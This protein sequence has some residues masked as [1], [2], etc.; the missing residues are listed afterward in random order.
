MNAKGSTRSRRQFVDQFRQQLLGG[1]GL[2]LPAP[3]R[4]ASGLSTL[5]AR[6]ASG[7]AE[8]ASVRGASS[9]WRC[10]SGDGPSAI[11]QESRRNGALALG[12]SL[13]LSPGSRTGLVRDSPALTPGHRA[14]AMPTCAIG[15]YC[16]PLEGDG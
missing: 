15:R 5:C 6:V 16:G 14:S 2:A 1:H 9:S 13:G 4:A 3:T 7:N 8:A 12:D 10:G 11:K